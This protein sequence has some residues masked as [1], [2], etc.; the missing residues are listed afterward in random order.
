MLEDSFSYAQLSEQNAQVNKC[1]NTTVIHQSDVL[2][3]LWTMGKSDLRFGCVIISPKTQFSRYNKARDS[4]FGRFNAPLLKGF[5][6]LCVRAARILVPGGYI[7]FQ[8]TLPGEREHWATNFLMT[9]LTRAG[10]TGTIIYESGITPEHGISAT[11]E[12]YWYPRMVVAR[13]D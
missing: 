1:D 6:K 3:E 12:D 9:G 10:K 13:V 7:V 8:A 5:E 4:Q 2:D 11:Q